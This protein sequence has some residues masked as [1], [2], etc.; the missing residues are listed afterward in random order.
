MLK[1]VCCFILCVLPVLLTVTTEA[2]TGVNACYKKQNGQLRILA[3]G[4]YCLPSE[5]S[6]V[7]T[8]VSQPAP[9]FWANANLVLHNAP[10]ETTPI[11]I[12][13]VTIDKKQTPSALKI[14]FSGGRLSF[15]CD[16]SNIQ[17]NSQAVFEVFLD[18]QAVAVSLN[19]DCCTAFRN[20]YAFVA[21]VLKD[22]PYG[23]HTVEVKAYKTQ[24]EGE[25]GSVTYT[26]YE[27][28]TPRT[29][30]ATLMVEEWPVGVE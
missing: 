27:P 1:R 19:Y 11:T 15:S 9:R 29:Y 13:Q 26:T 20:Q 21:T 10:L 18:G 25:G 8:T 14:T 24:N 30:K 23:Q 7:L 3:S 6:I 22:V 28:A 2:S 12:T 4:D 16:P 5:E 17:L